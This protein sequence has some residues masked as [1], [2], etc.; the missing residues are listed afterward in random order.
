MGLLGQQG[1]FLLWWIGIVSVLVEP[2]PEYL[3]RLFGQV[4]SPLPLP[5][6]SSIWREVK[7]HIQ[8][9]LILRLA[10]WHRQNT[11]VH[12]RPELKLKNFDIVY[13]AHAY[14]YTESTRESVKSDWCMSDAFVTS[15]KC[16]RE[17]VSW[18]SVCTHVCEGGQKTPSETST[19]PTPAED[20]PPPPILHTLAFHPKCQPL[21]ATQQRLA[22]CMHV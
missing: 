11:C 15:K 6:H 5:W 21:N 12:K 19:P 22:V 14:V 7:R 16:L 4:P 17:W 10:S 2:V 13:S 20:P 9:V 18:E 3:Y 8:T 1:F